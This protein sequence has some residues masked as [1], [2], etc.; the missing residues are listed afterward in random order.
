[1]T[2]RVGQKVVC[3]KEPSRDPLNTNEVVP[4]LGNI[5]T[6]RS[7]AEYI[8]GTGVRV[9]EIVNAPCLYADGFMEVAFAAFCFRPLVERKT[10]I[11]IFHRIL[12]EAST[13]S[14]SKIGAD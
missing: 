4:T 3:V 6:I 14:P 8:G 1:M 11:T 10:D 2:F 9:F 13:K 5:Y 12:D 7:I